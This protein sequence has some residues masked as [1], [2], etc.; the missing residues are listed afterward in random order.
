MKTTSSETVSLVTVCYNPGD[1]ILET[2]NSV[3]RQTYPDIEYIVIDG[4]STDGTF[5]SI[6]SSHSGINTLISEPD[7]GIYDAFNKGINQSTGDIIG[8]LNA[9][10]LFANAHVISRIVHVFNSCA[11][12]AVY[13]DLVYITKEMPNRVLRYW[14]SG[15]FSGKSLKMGWMPPHPTLFARRSVYDACKLSN[16]EYYDSTMHISADYDLMLRLLAYGNVRLAYL[17]DVLVLMRLGGISNRGLCNIILKMREDLLAMYRNNVGGWPTL[18]AKNLRKLPQITLRQQSPTPG[19]NIAGEMLRNAAFS[20]KH[21]PLLFL[22]L[23]Q[24]SMFL[25]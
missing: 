17:K 3:L 23:H 20:S 18:L 5:E 12:D 24:V 15:A 6:L 1:V 2:I 9:A 19:M 10:D 7:K 4:K 16:G 11:V 22:V 21:L 8:F 13:G 14:K 25:N